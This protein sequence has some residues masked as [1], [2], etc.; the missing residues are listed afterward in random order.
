MSCP[1]IKF[2]NADL[3]ISPVL[4][5][6]L[7]LAHSTSVHRECDTGA[8]AA[9]E[10]RLAGG[11]DRDQEQPAGSR[12]IEH[13]VRYPSPEFMRLLVELGKVVE[14]EDRRLGHHPDSTVRPKSSSKD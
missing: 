12:A 13:D 7:W 8:T 5:S 11:S 9:V 3:K 6:Q 1:L 2:E 4:N 10:R 14:R